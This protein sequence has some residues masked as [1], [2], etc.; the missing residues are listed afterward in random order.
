[1]KKTII[2][3]AILTSMSSAMAV[4]EEAKADIDMSDP[5]D[6]YT[7]LGLAYGDAGLDFKGMLMLSSTD[8]QKTGVIFEAKNMLDEHA[9]TIH[10]VT[11]D[12]VSAR[13]Y[14]LR[15]GTIN[16]QNGLG[17][18]IDAINAEHPFFGNMTVVQ[19]GPNMTIPVGDSF[20]IWPI[21]YV[22][23]V[24]V[25]NNGD[26]PLTPRDSNY[27]SEGI[28][29]SSAIVTGM[30]YA[31]YAITDQLWALGSYSYTTDIQG[32]SWS[33]AV[34][35]GGLQM[36]NSKYDLTI[37]YQFTDRQNVTLIYRGDDSDDT[38]DSFA[39]GYNYAF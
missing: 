5:T 39:V 3:L 35:D 14:R 22:G 10:D 15:W 27:S 20:L 1:M 38:D 8:T 2:T 18:S 17:W 21:V 36:A 28:N 26:S 7:T 33:D 16:T 24:F 19:T 34:G 25:E 30:V 12:E 6:V 32:K 11:G 23:G 31:R 29:V 9:D 37:G 13:S 4:A